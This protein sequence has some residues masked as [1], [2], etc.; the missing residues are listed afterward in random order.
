MKY[1][2]DGSEISVGDRVVVEGDVPGI[3]VCDFDRW[4]CLDGYEDWLTK[5][6]LVGGGRLES[7]VM[8]KT[9][10]LGYVHYAEPDQQIVKAI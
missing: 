2:N 10:K 6:E 9:E 8:I 5:K 7:G 1:T 3:V 4:R